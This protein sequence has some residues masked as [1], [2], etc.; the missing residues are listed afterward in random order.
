MNECH[1]YSMYNVVLFILFCF[2][3]KTQFF[4]KKKIIIKYSRFVKPLTGCLGLSIMRLLLFYCFDIE[5]RKEKEQFKRNTR[6]SVEK[7]NEKREKKNSLK[8][9]F[10]DY[11]STTRN[12]IISGGQNIVKRFFKERR[13]KKR[14]NDQTDF[15]R[16]LSMYALRSIQ[17]ISCKFFRL[18][19]ASC[20]PKYNIK[21]K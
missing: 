17:F 11:Y 12:P 3:C 9:K 14:D 16:R 10:Y 8:I 15:H 6:K 18:S 19:V 1:F 13:R 4:I 5:L 2:I 20:Q 21:Y 7:Q